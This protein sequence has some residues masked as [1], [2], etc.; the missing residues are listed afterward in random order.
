M[1]TSTLKFKKTNKITW[2]IPWQ[3]FRGANRNCFDL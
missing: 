2:R 1:P 3:R